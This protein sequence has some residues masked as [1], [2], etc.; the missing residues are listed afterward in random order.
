[1]TDY[2]LVPVELIER[3]VS[4]AK[5][6][7]KAEPLY[8]CVGYHGDEQIS[9]Y[10]EEASDLACLVLDELSDAAPAPNIL[11]AAPEPVSDTAAPVVGDP[12]SY[13]VHPDIEH[14]PIKAHV[15]RRESTHEW[16]LEMNGSINDTCFTIRHPQPLNMAPEDAIGLPDLYANQEKLDV[17]VKALED[18]EDNSCAVEPHKLQTALDC[19]SSIAS[20]SLSQI[21]GGAL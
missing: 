16:V 19:I 9:S 5:A 1:M 13:P 18:I 14:Y 10:I 15:W 2:K 6:I 7:M 4:M 17:A 8:G 21:K 12:V 3:A 11:A 20:K